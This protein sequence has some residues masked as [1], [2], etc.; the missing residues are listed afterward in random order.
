MAKYFATIANEKGEA[1]RYPF[2]SWV[3][4]HMTELPAN[5]PVGGTT[6]QWKRPLLRLGWV[7]SAGD[8]TV[9]MINPD[10]NHSVEYAND[11]VEELDLEA[12]ENEEET[13]QAQEITFGL[14]K[15]LQHALRQNIESLERGLKIIDG[16][17]E[18][19]TEAGFID[20]TAKDKQERIVVIEL[21]APIG[22]PEVIA[23][24][25]AYMEAVHAAEKKEVRELSLPA[26]SWIV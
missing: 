16:G 15:D 17:K 10:A 8:D 11:Y 19:H 12:E 3:R 1:V 21:K 13:E 24:T 5:F 20:I 7:E 18:R 25:L 22:K 26:I 2:K 14:E 23:Q 6:R 4:Q 9:Y